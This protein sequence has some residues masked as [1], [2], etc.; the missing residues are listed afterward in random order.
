MSAN[1]GFLTPPPGLVPAAPAAETVKPEAA[2][3]QEFISLP[4]GVSAPALDSATLKVDNA[5]RVRPEP[6]ETAAPVFVP[7]VAPGLP[8]A[9]VAAVDE[10]AD[11][12][13]NF[14]I[15]D[16]TRV[17]VSR[18]LATGWRIA[19]PDGGYLRI[20]R[21]ALI[22]RAPATNPRWPD[23]QLLPIV[24][25]AKSVS[26]T[27]AAFELAADGTLRVHD[28]DSTNGV[29]VVSATGEEFDVPVG[30]GLTI[31]DG[32]VVSLGEFDMR[33]HRAAGTS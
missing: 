2:E 1:D 8:V 22:G 20:Q 15:D 33:V 27:H 26:K 13:S 3:P 19:L 30:T 10:V 18:L 5:R 12:T 23:A 21:T 28:L 6:R 4:P 25:P 32:A 7:M 16:A 11:A 31:D 17:S 24:D 29:Y 14:E 9:T